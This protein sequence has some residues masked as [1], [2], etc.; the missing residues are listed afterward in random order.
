MSL[1][2]FWLRVIVTRE[3]KDTRRTKEQL[4]QIKGKELKHTHTLTH[5]L[6]HTNQSPLCRRAAARQRLSGNHLL[7]VVNEGEKGS[8][9]V[10]GNNGA[11]ATS[12]RR[13]AGNHVTDGF[14]FIL[15]IQQTLLWLK[16]YFQTGLKRFKQILR[17]IF[18]ALDWTFFF[19]IQCY[20][21]W[22]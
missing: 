14:L 7:K 20:N 19:I 8:D 16:F 2:C 1:F 15:K 17:G 22:C 11:I 5:T 10:W 3:R 6:T 21:M 13:R 4:V 9:G 12:S 18:Q